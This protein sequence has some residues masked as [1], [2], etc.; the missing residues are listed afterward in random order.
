MPEEA[1]TSV[2]S[3][4]FLVVDLYCLLVGDGNK[5]ASH[6]APAGG[7]TPDPLLF[8]PGPIKMDLLYLPG[9]SLETYTAWSALEY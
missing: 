9:T 6:L 8:L 2:R 1:F 3:T 7:G 5:G 4:S